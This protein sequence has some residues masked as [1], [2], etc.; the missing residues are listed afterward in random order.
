MRAAA[1]MVVIG[2]KVADQVLYKLA[3]PGRYLRI[4]SVAFQVTGLLQGESPR[5]RRPGLP[6]LRMAG[7]GPCACIPAWDMNDDV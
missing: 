2:Q 4:E 1:R 3:P 6:A 7:A 5:Q